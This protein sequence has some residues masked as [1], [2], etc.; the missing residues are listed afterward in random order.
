LA[1]LLEVEQTTVPYREFDTWRETAAKKLN[2]KRASRN[3]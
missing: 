1:R 3:A 2:P